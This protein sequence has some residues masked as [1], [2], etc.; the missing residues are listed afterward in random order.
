[1]ERALKNSRLPSKDRTSLGQ[2]IAVRRRSDASRNWRVTVNNASPGHDPGADAAGYCRLSALD[3]WAT[4]CALIAAREVFRRRI[5]DGGV[6]VTPPVILCSPHLGARRQRLFCDSHSKRVVR[7]I[8]TRRSNQGFALEWPALGRR[9]SA[10][11]RTIYRRKCE[12][13]RTAARVGRARGF[14]VSYPALAALR[15]T[16]EASSSIWAARLWRNI[17]KPVRAY[18]LTAPASS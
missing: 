13:R 12:R 8:C 14:A 18:R 3:E 16:A 10:V 4:V 2:D 17:A 6:V 7:T 15:G 11:G 5:A 1:M 9:N